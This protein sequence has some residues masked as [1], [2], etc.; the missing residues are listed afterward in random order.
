MV[1]FTYNL[2]FYTIDFYQIAPESYLGT[3][4]TILYTQQ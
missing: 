4:T 3:P 1:Y 2:I